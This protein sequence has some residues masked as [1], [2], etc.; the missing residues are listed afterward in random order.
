MQNREEKP[1]VEKQSLQVCDPLMSHPLLPKFNIPEV[2]LPRLDPD[3]EKQ[4]YVLSY[5]KL[6]LRRSIRVRV[7]I[8]NLM[9]H[10]RV[11]QPSVHW[12]TQ[13]SLAA[14]LAAVGNNRLSGSVST[15]VNAR[16]R[17]RR[18]L[19]R[20]SQNL[21]HR[22][23]SPLRAEWRPGDDHYASNTALMSTY[24]RHVED[25]T[26]DAAAKAELAVRK[27]SVDSLYGPPS[28]S[29]LPLKATIGHRASLPE[30][31]I[32]GWQSGSHSIFI[33]PCPSSSPLRHI[34]ASSFASTE[35][36]SSSVAH[37]AAAKPVWRKNPWKSI[38]RVMSCSALSLRPWKGNHERT[39]GGKLGNLDFPPEQQE[40]QQQSP[41]CVLDTVAHTEAFR[42]PF[43]KSTDSFWRRIVL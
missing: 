37:Q 7:P 39:A 30:M 17:N 29:H 34:S 4:T 23:P 16:R 12:T 27:M 14:T 42:A 21:S 10:I 18:R 43:R 1:F 36:P 5:R 40:Q 22:D 38:K 8:A 25:V 9:S 3:L 31:K 26:R 6:L 33:K 20:I 11:V 2:I 15:S 24:S 32:N 13:E 41:H 35:F 28:A 19:N